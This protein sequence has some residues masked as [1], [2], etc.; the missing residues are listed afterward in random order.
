MPR[1]ELE[2]TI[3]VF[4]RTKICDA[5]DRAA[6]MLGS[7]SGYLEKLMKYIEHSFHMAVVLCG[8]TVS[9]ALYVLLCHRQACWQLYCMALQLL[10]RCG[11]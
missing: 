9:V 1:V 3:P 8:I 11:M 5:L 10:L 2:P 6:T 7:Y 4:E